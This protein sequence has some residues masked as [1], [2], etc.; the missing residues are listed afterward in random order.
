MPTKETLRERRSIHREISPY[1]DKEDEDEDDTEFSDEDEKEIDDENRK[2]P[3][4]RGIGN[5]FKA[6]A[7]MGWTPTY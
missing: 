4:A 6:L 5:A 7:G 1:A 3:S 2:L